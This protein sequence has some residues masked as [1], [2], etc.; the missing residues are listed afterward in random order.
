M[1]TQTDKLNALEAL[2]D[3]YI[4]WHLYRESLLDRDQTDNPAPEYAWEESHL[5]A[6]ELLRQMATALGW[7]A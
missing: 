5:D 2:K 6:A 3:A 4:D 7:D 1:S